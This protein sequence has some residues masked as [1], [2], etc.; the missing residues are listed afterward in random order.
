MNLAE[1]F[2]TSFVEQHPSFPITFCKC[3]PDV[4][5]LM[6]HDYIASSAKV[7]RTAFLIPLIQLQH[8]IWQVLIISALGLTKAL[9]SF[10]D[11]QHKQPLLGRG[12]DKSG[13]L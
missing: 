7:P 12:Y 3:I 9:M 4:I 5:R 8:Q 2:L 6:Y 13:Q 10:L 1:D 11:N